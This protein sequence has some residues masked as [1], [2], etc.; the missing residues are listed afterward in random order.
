MFGLPQ[1]STLLLFR[2]LPCPWPSAF[3]LPPLAPSFGDAKDPGVEDV[4]LGW[5]EVGETC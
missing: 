4:R 5:I 3:R 1:L 2:D